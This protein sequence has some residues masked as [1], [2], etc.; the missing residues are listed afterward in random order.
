MVVT[1]W[2]DEGGVRARISH[3]TSGLR[4]TRAVASVDDLITAIRTLVESWDDVPTR[5]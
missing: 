2:H 4:H 5:Y 3:G 1:V